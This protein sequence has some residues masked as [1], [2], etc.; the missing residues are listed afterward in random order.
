MGQPLN[1]STQCHLVILHK[2]TKNVA[3]VLNSS[4]KY[5][6]KNIFWRGTSICKS[7]SGTASIQSRHSSTGSVSASWTCDL[8]H[9]ALNSTTR[10][11]KDSI[12]DG[13]KIPVSVW[14]RCQPSIVRNLGVYCFI[15]VIPIKK[16]NYGWGIDVLIVYL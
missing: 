6:Q 9:G 2:K 5:R 1:Y 13:E 16:A 4:Y 12:P 14:D 7:I 8:R 11:S 10:C 3:L 15:S